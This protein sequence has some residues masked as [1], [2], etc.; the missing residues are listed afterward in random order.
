M[1]DIIADRV[2]VKK[3]KSSSTEANTKSG[4]V[5]LGTGLDCA[6]LSNAIVQHSR[7]RFKEIVFIL[8]NN[9]LTRTKLCQSSKVED[10]TK[11]LT[12][13]KRNAKYMKGGIF[14]VTEV[15]FYFDLYEKNFDAKD[16]KKL[17]IL[18]RSDVDSISPLSAAVTKLKMENPVRP[19]RLPF[20][21]SA[22]GPSR[23][24]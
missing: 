19:I 23:C 13:R 2:L 17:I 3:N 9:E 18:D 12:V 1:Y 21:R 16:L 11:S 4:L 15:I 24:R 8:S 14:F 22:H 5:I 10:L 20:F 6:K 7:V